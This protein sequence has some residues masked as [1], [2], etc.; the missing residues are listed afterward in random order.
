[1]IANNLEDMAETLLSQLNSGEIDFE[2]SDIQ[3]GVSKEAARTQFAEWVEDVQSDPDASEEISEMLKAAAVERRMVLL[4]SPD[5]VTDA[6][7]AA[8]LETSGTYQR[9]F[10]LGSVFPLTD[11]PDGPSATIGTRGEIAAPEYQV[12]NVATTREEALASWATNW[13][14]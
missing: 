9:L 1:M 6:E 10:D 8:W 2:P 5:L 4:S 13:L 12:F 3:V 14:Q 11:D 7:L